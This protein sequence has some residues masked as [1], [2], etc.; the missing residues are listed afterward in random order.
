MEARA[1]KA[2]EATRG[3]A[4]ELEE[5]MIPEMANRLVSVDTYSRRDFGRFARQ[6]VDLGMPVPNNVARDE[7]CPPGPQYADRVMAAPVD[8]SW[9]RKK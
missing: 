8:E 4:R 2:I 5:K 7:R 3:F 1:L 6:C 9:R